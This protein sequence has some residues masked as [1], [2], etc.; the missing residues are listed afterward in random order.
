MEGTTVEQAKEVLKEAGYFVGN[1]WHI[2]DVQDK[3]ECTD[4]EA[5]EVLSQA[6]EN[7]ATMEQIWYAIGHHAEDN[8]LTEIE[9]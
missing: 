5:Q 4:E 8:E 3:F 1:L 2:S 7:D 6:L 9:D